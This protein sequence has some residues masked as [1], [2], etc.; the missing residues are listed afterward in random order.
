M[1]VGSNTES[2][3]PRKSERGI[4]V[5]EMALVSSLVMMLMGGVFDLANYFQTRSRI[6]FAVS[7]AARFAV[8]GNQVTDPTDPGALLSREDSIMHML[9]K[10]SGIPFDAT[11]V[12]I[13]T[14][15]PDGT[16]T[17]GAGGPGDIV[18]VRVNYDLN[19]VTPGVN[20]IFDSG[21]APIRCSTRY[22]NEEFTS[23]LFTLPDCATGNCE[24]LV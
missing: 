16:L 18:L 19:V 2:R 23:S 1:T 20:K 13:L 21:T 8:T 14:V 9:G 15:Q 3:K 6:Q 17:P 4:V 11:Q 5:L 12:T 10:V 7:Q 24:A 22:R